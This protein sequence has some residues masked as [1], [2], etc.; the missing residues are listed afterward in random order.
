MQNQADATEGSTHSGTPT[1]T[2]LALFLVGV[3]IALQD[4]RRAGCSPWLRELNPRRGSWNG[5]VFG[6]GVRSGARR[7][8]RVL[9]L[10]ALHRGIDEGGLPAER[11]EAAAAVRAGTV[12]GAGPDDARAFGSLEVR[13]AV[14]WSRREVLTTHAGEPDRMARCPICQ[15]AIETDHDEAL[16]MK[17]SC[18]RAPADPPH[19]A[20]PILAPA[21]RP[22]E[23]REVRC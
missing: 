22:A 17:P 3:P 5:S 13:S 19:A 9:Q 4:A 21:S 8:S 2:R 1:G 10:A 7:S 12:A 23:T 18:R 15:M 14:G 6:D 16:R 11:H 20:A